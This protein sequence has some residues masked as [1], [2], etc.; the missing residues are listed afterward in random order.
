MPIKIEDLKPGY[1]YKTKTNTYSLFIGMVSTQSMKL[2]KL[3]H[4][5]KT[6]TDADFLKTSNTEPA[7]LRRRNEHKAWDTNRIKVVTKYIEYG[8][9]WFELSS[10]AQFLFSHPELK[11]RE[12]LESIQQYISRALDG[13]LFSYD[14]HQFKLRERVSFEEVVFDKQ[15]DFDNGEVISKLKQFTSNLDLIKTGPDDIRLR[16]WRLFYV[17]DKIHMFA[18]MTYFGCYPYFNVVYE[19]V[20]PYFLSKNTVA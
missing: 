4:F 15:F 7:L 6:N 19:D 20:K 16:L 8:T 5:V 12:S 3:K 2:V 1:I 17:N 11:S 10:E 18:N 14:V 13:K 9:L